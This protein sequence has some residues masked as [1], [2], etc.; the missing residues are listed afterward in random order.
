MM[1]HFDRGVDYTTD[2]YRRLDARKTSLYTRAVPN[3]LFGL[4]SRP[5]DVLVFGGS[6]PNTSNWSSIEGTV[7][8]CE[9]E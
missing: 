3:V 9:S 5:N 7:D 6:R 4:N 2:I 8:S 1:P